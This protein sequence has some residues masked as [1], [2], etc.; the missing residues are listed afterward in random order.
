MVNAH[1]SEMQKL[2]NRE[3]K[4]LVEVQPGILIVHAGASKP[5]GLWV[6]LWRCADLQ[7]VSNRGNTSD[8]SSRRPDS[9]QL[10]FFIP[11]EVMEVQPFL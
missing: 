9:L 4:E 2:R 7:S 1:I 10:P 6:I 8:Q 3:V 11:F 5:G